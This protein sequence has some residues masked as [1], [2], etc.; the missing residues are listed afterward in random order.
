VKFGT[1]TAKFTKTATS[2]VITVPAGATGTSAVTVLYAGGTIAV[3][4]WEYMGATKRAQTLTPTGLGAA[5]F[6]GASDANRNLSV[7]SSI[8]GYTVT[9]TSKTPAVC[10]FVQGVIDFVGNGTCVIQATQAGDAVTAAATS[11]YEIYYESPITASALYSTDA[12]KPTITLTGVGL[13]AVSKVMFGSVEVVPTKKTDTSI[14]VKV[15]AAP[16]AGANVD[17]QLKYNNGTIVDTELD[18]DFVGALKIVQTLTF[19]AGFALADYGDAVR[20][21][22]TVS[23]DAED[24]VLPDLPYVYSTSTPDVC[25]VDGNQLRF[26]AG[27][28]C[29][30]KVTQ[31]GNVGVAAATASFNIIVSKKAQ[32][33]T[34]NN[35]LSVTD[36]TGANLAATNSNDEV[37]LDYESSDESICTVDGEGFVTGIAAG[38]CEITIT[39]EGDDRYLEDIKTVTV[40]VTADNVTVV[41]EEAADVVDETPIAISNGGANAFIS[42]SDP[43]LQVSWD[44]ANGK[45]TPRATGVYTGNIVATLK[46]TVGGVDKF[47]TT[48]FG[49]TTAL[50]VPAKP[51]LPENATP[52]QAL[53]YAKAFAAYKKAYN[54]A[55]GSKIFKSAV[56]CADGNKLTGTTFGTLKKVAK[57]AA[58]KK[59]EAANLKLLKNYTGTVEISVKRWRAWPTTAKNK[60][61]N[62]LT[63]KTIPATKNINSLTLG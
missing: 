23:K 6:T 53:A 26:V 9:I 36:V 40:T 41:P 63:G 2:L 14:T 34:V 24:N 33:I 1:V 51:V 44:K 56:F 37:V 18:F 20:T 48:V 3:G 19:S 47:C 50:K 35:T 55:F 13:G 39:A 60:T 21:L 25:D 61:G 22:S 27:G 59:V 54:A 52:K 32:T 12:A 45:L 28:T 42:L 15:P 30:V 16:S 11:T 57:T 17:I 38:S 49:S 8:D 7:A 29:T 62:G 46:F 5:T 31:P 43:S 10:T 58:E 4:D